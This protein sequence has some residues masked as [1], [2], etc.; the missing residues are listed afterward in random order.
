M[1]EIGSL[2]VGDP[3]EVWHDLGFAAGSDG[4]VVVDG[5]VHRFD[6]AVGK[7]IRGWALRGTD[8]LGPTFE[9]IPTEA[10]SPE[11][12]GD[13]THANGVVGL[14]HVVLLTPDLAR[15][16]ERLEGAGVE[17]RRVRETDTYGSPMRQAFFRFGP[18]ILEVIGSVEKTGDGPARFYG[19]AWTV[20]DLDATAAFLG[21]RLRPAKEAV[22]P[23]RRIATLDRS[24]G[25]TV[26]MAFMSPGEP[27][28]G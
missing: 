6:P 3:A 1:V 27:A 20:A 19:L 4:H 15:T 28:V 22:Q 5:V 17:C 12:G 7:G 14:D 11:P 13:G 16:I 9:G 25:S 2:T 26:A 23:G 18:V 21:D 8:D 24:A 10:A